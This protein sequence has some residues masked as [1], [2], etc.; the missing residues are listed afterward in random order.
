M[1]DAVDADGNDTPTVK[2]EILFDGE[3]DIE[4]YCM[5]EEEKEQLLRRPQGLFLCR[6]R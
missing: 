6:R 4:V 5:E 2:S 1:E 3:E